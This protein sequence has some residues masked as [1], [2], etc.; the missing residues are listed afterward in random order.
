MGKFTDPDFELALATV[1][2]GVGAARV[3]VLDIPA[4]SII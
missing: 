1:K 4:L 3:R 2:A